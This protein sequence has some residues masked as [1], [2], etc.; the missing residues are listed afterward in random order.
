MLLLKDK[1][2]AIGKRSKQIQ[3]ITSVYLL[4]TLKSSKNMQSMKLDKSIIA[5]VTYVQNKCRKHI[6]SFCAKML[7]NKTV[8]RHQLYTVFV[9]Y[10]Q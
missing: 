4:V 10:H 2:G 7:V 1:K 6:I 3:F 8:L 5:L 9:L